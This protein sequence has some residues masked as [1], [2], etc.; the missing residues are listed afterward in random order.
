MAVQTVKELRN[1]VMY[2]VF[3]RQFS[4][5][6]TFARVQEALPRIRGLGV[7]ILWLLPIHPIGVQCRK[8]ALGSPY[9]IRDYRAVNPEFGTPED[10]RTL[11]ETA[12]A[13]GMKVIIDV[14]YNHTSP[15]SVLAVEHPD[16]FYHKPDG[17]FG[18]KTG[19]WTDIADLDYGKPAL[20]DYQI[21]TLLTWAK[22]VD[23]FRCDVAPLIPLSFWLKARAAV[24][25][26][27]P[28]CLW[29]SETV[30]P[31][32]TVDNR[33]RGMVSLSDSEIYQAFD[34]G[35]EYDI[36]GD[37][38]RCLQDKCSLGEYAEAINR[39]EHIYPDNYVK[40]RFLENHDRPRAAQIIPDERR[41]RNWTA[42]LYFQ[43][44]MTLLYNG[45]ETE[46]RLR[47]NL[48]D[49]DAVRWDT[50]RDLSPLLKR[51]Y[52]I[53]RREVFTNSAYRV[54]DVGNGIL[55]ATHRSPAGKALGV[56]STRGETAPV[57]VEWP[58]G[59]AVNLIDGRTLLVE[60][61]L[62]SCDGEPVILIA[63]E[64]GS[65]GFRN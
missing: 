19:E 7:D 39:Q 41:L 49:K 37:F 40:L 26:V 18:S 57:T 53:K 11:V 32:F 65:H 44:G 16:W 24:E 3:V 51:L 10:F 35:Y 14:V 56:F 15:D 60:N 46:N 30:E 54:R 27:R 62:L 20:W 59:E 28:G 43:K 1:Q 38:M 64:E 21:E 63:D 50:G 6:G 22:T 42:F 48:F 52:R 29:L 9:A 17:S 58:D 2:S 5:E 8:G 25:T 34:L 4:A 47:P 55:T 13:L 31:A 33:A 36:Y 45:Q 23:G 12:H 61:G